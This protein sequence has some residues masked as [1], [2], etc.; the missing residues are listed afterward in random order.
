MK[1][2]QLI[3]CAG[4]VMLWAANGVAN[5]ADNANGGAPGAWDQQ[6]QARDMTGKR[7]QE[8][9]DLHTGSFNYSIPIN[10]APARNGSQP[11][12]ALTY[13]SGAENGWCGMGWK[14]D[15]GY[16]ERNTKDGFPIR[17]TTATIPMPATA[18]D[19]TKGFLLNLY[20]KESKLYAVATNSPT[21]EYRAETDTDFLRC[22]LNTNNNNWTVYDKSGNAYHFG[23]S[24]SSQV[25]NPKTGWSGYSGTF[26]WGLD[27]VDSATGDQT[28]VAYATYKDPAMNSLPERTIYPTQITYN[29]HTSLNGYNA[30]ASGNCT[31]S[32]ATEIR[33]DERN[34]Y[35][36]GFRAEQNRRLT[37]IVCQV[38]SQKVW[39]Y[40]LGYT[41]S[42]ATGRSLLSSVTAYGSDDSTYLPV[43]TF[44]YQ[45]NP[46]GV[47]FGATAAWTN[48][49]LSDLSGAG[50]TDP[51]L[52]QINTS[53][54]TVADLFDIDGDGLPDRV[55]Y[56][57]GGSGNYDTYQVQRNNGAGGFGARYTFGTSSSSSSSTASDA[58]LV[59]AS[60]TYSALNGQQ[61][62]LHD[63]NGDGLPDRINDWWKHFLYA[64]AG[65]VDFI[66]RHVVSTLIA[67]PSNGLV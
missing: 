44:T 49:I 46:K 20:G 28:T 39:R 32:F 25:A 18:Y 64:Q 62:R 52:T 27:E 42:T 6:I 15:L 11:A 65:L 47:S 58:N 8:Q 67:I 51:C 40:A 48:M 29:G 1:R 14:L 35:R 38:G 3:F 4:M 63:I 26:H 13:T 56:C 24:S 61:T 2:R 16:I 21:V 34:S 43:Q 23:Q 41:T 50:G 57:Y 30:S 54:T 36:W 60:G 45:Q 31:I 66:D 5:T 19:D 59:P 17:Y 9:V 55:S 33:P 53:G 22:L 10:C 12:L 7:G 37:N